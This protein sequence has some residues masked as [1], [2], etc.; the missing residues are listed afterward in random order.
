MTMNIRTQ[1]SLHEHCI[2]IVLLVTFVAADGFA[3]ACVHLST[4][5]HVV[6][7]SAPIEHVK[8][9]DDAGLCR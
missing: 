8:T 7:L 9:C 4:D 1:R 6:Y 5:G 3:L 2:S